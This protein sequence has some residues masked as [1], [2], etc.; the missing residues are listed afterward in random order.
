MPSDIIR[1]IPDGNKAV[2]ASRM[3]ERMARH[4]G[5]GNKLP[6]VRD[7]C[8]TMQI[9]RYTMDA[10]L[11]DLE[12]QGLLARKHGS[13]LYVTSLVQTRRIAFVVRRDIIESSKGAA[14]S[15]HLIIDGLRAEGA[16]RNT[17]LTC[18]SYDPNHDK[19]KFGLQPIEWDVQNGRVDGVIVGGLN[20][21]QGNPLQTLGIPCV[22]ISGDVDHRAVQVRYDFP[23]MISKGAQ[24]LLQAGRRRVGLAYPVRA[25]NSAFGD[26]L[27]L[28]RQSMREMGIEEDSR[29]LMPFSADEVRIR[30]LEA[31]RQFHRLWERPDRPDALLSLDDQFTAGLLHAVEVLRV[32]IPGDLLVASH[33]NKGLNLFDHHSVIR[34]EYDMGDIAA[35]LLGALDDLIAGR[36]AT[37]VQS[38]PPQVIWPD[39]D[40]TSTAPRF[41]ALVE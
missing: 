34:I 21:T 15:T 13:G 30:A 14:D 19:E 17:L 31:S 22:V 23:A 6:T 40:F 1:P 20:A 33:A 35:R 41:E 3:L 5:P 16:R 7:L 39:A 38:V 12:A 8:K 2:D 36:K 11:N 24:A 25:N 28:F 10:A 37:P 32:E 26:S 18:Y 27:E 4:I 29:W 9:S